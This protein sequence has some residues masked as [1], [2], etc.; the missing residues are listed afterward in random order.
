MNERLTI[1]AQLWAGM[2]ANRKLYWADVLSTHTKLEE[3][4]RK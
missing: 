2:P 4:T 1:A 3:V